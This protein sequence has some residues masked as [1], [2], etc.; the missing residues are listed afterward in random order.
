MNALR[1]RPTQA[2]VAALIA[3]A[4]FAATVGGT[5]IGYQQ[6]AAQAVVE[7]PVTVASAATQRG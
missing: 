6:V 4:G 1:I 3:V 5:V 7:T 2:L